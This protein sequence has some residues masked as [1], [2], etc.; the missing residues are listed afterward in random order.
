M[1]VTGGAT[2]TTATV[3][4]VVQNA[5]TSTPIAGANVV[6]TAS[7]NPTV[8]VTTDATGKYTA[9]GLP[10]GSFTISVTATGYQAF[11]ASG[12]LALGVNDAGTIKLQPLPAASTISGVVVDGMTQAPIAGAQVV[13]QGPATTVTT[14]S[15][16]EYTL[17]DVVGPQVTLKAT[18]S[19]YLSQTSVVSVAA[20]AVTTLNFTLYQP[21]ATGVS[22]VSAATSKAY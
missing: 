18:A 16:G 22:I 14:N 8:T 15:A 5:S 19:G 11:N 2:P 10:A 21:T 17:T 3:Q 13:V 9:T 7:G 1:V 4:G 20:G 6:I 12:S